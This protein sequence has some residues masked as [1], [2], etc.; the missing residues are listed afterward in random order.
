MAPAVITEADAANL[1]LLGL[2][3]L[4]ALLMRA[5]VVACDEVPADVVTMNSRL[6]YSDA[7]TGEHQRVVIVYPEYAAPDAGRISVLSPAGMALLGLSAGQRTQCVFPDG[8]RHYLRVEAVLH[9][10]EYKLR[11]Q[12][13]VRG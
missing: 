4:L 12:L 13:I 3:Q 7:T 8:I 6:L 11:T 9:Q 10:P 2:P 5:T 1:S